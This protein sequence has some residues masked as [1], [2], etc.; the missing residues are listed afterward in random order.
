[1]RHEI[2]EGRTT[3]QHLAALSVDEIADIARGQGYGQPYTVADAVHRGALQT[4][5]KELDA[6][7]GETNR[8]GRA[9]LCLLEGTV[10]TRPE[11]EAVLEN[12]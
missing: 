7:L 1:M 6:L 12:K 4:R 11:A 9:T 5:R 2:P 3:A 8:V 10:V